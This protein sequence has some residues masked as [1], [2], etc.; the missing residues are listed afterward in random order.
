M[1]QRPSL[2]GATATSLRS[3]GSGS[4]SGEI[5]LRS[6]F[7]KFIY[8]D[9][10]NVRHGHL[11]LIRHA[12]RDADGHPTRCVCLADQA[13]REP[14]L[15]CSYCLGEGHLWDEQ[16]HM[17]YS[18]Y[19]GPDGGQSSRFRWLWPGTL[20]TDTLVFWFRYS[21]SITY[22]DKVIEVV[23]D[24]EGA[25]QLPYV[26]RSVHRPNTIQEMRSDRGRIEFYTVFCRQEDS[27]RNESTS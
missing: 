21:V 23:L 2:Y 8:G 22:E 3:H 1:I 7:D 11:V 4:G 25:P 10:D 18:A 19:V 24:E 15:D 14:D 20:R 9:D 5:D 26:R 27:I 12:R 17:T 16:W 6:E 13:T